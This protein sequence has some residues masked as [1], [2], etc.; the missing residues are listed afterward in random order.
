[1]E[2]LA[3]RS[4]RTRENSQ[5]Q[6]LKQQ[7]KRLQR[8]WR[9]RAAT[10]SF[11]AQIEDNE[12]KETQKR[13]ER[14][15]RIS[16]EGNAIDQLDSAFGYF[17]K[18]TKKAYA[19]V[20]EEEHRYTD[21]TAAEVEEEEMDRDREEDTGQQDETQS[22]ETDESYQPSRSPTITPTKQR[23][24]WGVI[25]NTG[26]GVLDYPSSWRTPWVL[27]DVNVAELLWD[28]RQSVVAVLP[29]LDAPIESL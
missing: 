20:A 16:L 13:N 18:K 11:W 8:E 21:L 6:N 2:N 9:D 1:M 10:E 19:P 7:Y 25:Y 17:S 28:F 5:H 12:L 23:V 15:H 27:D 4:G 3:R 24:P 22:S 26:E 14:K 29:N